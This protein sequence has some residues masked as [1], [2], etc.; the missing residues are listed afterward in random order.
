MSDV[1]NKE[2]LVS[3][4][5]TKSGETVASTAKIID[6]FF[7]VV[8]ETIKEGGKV[9]IT[10]WLSFE[11]GYRAERQGVNPRTGEKIQIA[12]THTAKVKA[13]SK[14]KEKAKGN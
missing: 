9:A 13:G 11:R 12:A 2:S 4:I 8:G 14:L 1:L 7:E 6:T 3:M 10:G 5:S